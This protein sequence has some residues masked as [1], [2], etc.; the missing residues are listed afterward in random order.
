[1]K[2]LGTWKLEESHINRTQEIE[3][4]ISVMED[5]TREMVTSV[6]EIIKTKHDPAIKHPGIVV[7]YEKIKSTNNTSRGSRSPDS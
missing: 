1:M 4:R 3:G 2:N 7:H 5:K 6:K